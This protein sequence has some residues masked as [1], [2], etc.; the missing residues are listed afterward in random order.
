MFL[1]KRFASLGNMVSFPFCPF[2]CFLLTFESGD[3]DSF[4]I[5]TSLAVAIFVARTH[6]GCMAIVK[7]NILV[8]AVLQFVFVLVEGKQCRKTRL[9]FSFCCGLT[10]FALELAFSI[11]SNSSK[12]Q[13]SFNAVR[14]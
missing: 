6:L 3:V 9:L 11:I 4:Y 7:V 10:P 12:G 14:L 1:S 13:C 5:H 2:G 8:A